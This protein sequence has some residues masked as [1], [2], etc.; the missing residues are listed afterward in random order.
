MKTG[1]IIS[2]VVSV[3]GAVCAILYG[4]FMIKFNAIE[5]GVCGIAVAVT[6]CALS[7]MIARLL[8]IY[9]KEA[10]EERG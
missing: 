5:L 7:A 8:H 1:K 9:S 2:A 3:F 10:K 6:L 4:W